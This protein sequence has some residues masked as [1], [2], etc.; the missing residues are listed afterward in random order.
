MRIIKAVK[1][2]SEFIE[3]TLR[4]C[5]TD[6]DINEAIVTMTDNL[7]E[8]GYLG[9]KL[10][11]PMGM[12]CVIGNSIA[13]KAMI[14]RCDGYNID[15][16]LIV[17]SEHEIE[18]AQLKYGKHFPNWL[19]MDFARRVDYLAGIYGAKKVNGGAAAYA[20]KK[21]ESYR[22]EAAFGMEVI[23][24]GEILDE[25]SRASVTFSTS[26]LSIIGYALKAKKIRHILFDLSVEDLANQNMPEGKI[27][28]FNSSHSQTV[29]APVFRTSYKADV[30]SALPNC[31][32]G[33]SP[34]ELARIEFENMGLIENIKD[35]IKDRYA[36]WA[37]GIE[38]IHTV[39][40]DC[41]GYL[42]CIVATPDNNGKLKVL[43]VKY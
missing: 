5:N 38:N 29:L 1:Q 24:P 16:R 36:I 22:R 33:E 6:A 34:H 19:L 39:I 13:D 20:E 27:R 3:E 18:Q 9:S 15:K 8:F 31:S 10:G 28:A 35:E 21:L 41:C 2:D 12:R 11:E 4:A 7:Q 25:K 42:V 17:Y 43:A 32:V 30:M 40:D 23:D 14:A 26:L 37:D